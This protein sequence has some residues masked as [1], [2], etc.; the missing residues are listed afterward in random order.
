MAAFTTVRRWLAESA[1]HTRTTSMRSCKPRSCEP[2]AAAVVA[3]VRLPLDYARL[4]ASAI[5]AT[6]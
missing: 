4:N 1:R 2:F 5:R 3:Q 6:V